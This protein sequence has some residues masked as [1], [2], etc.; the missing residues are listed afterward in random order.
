[1]IETMIEWAWLA[2]GVY[3][4]VGFALLVP[5][6]WQG[7]RAIDGNTAGAS[8][9]FRLIISPSL[10]ALWPV[11][12]KKWIAAR[13]SVSSAPSPDRPVS[14]SALRKTQKHLI[15]AVAVLT[16]VAVGIA[17]MGR[18]DFASVA[19][20]AVD[21]RLLLEI[22][23]DLELPTTVLYL[24]QAAGDTLSQSAI[25][26]GGIWGPASFSF[27]LPNGTEPVGMLKVYSLAN[28]VVVGASE[29][30]GRADGRS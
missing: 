7:L 28:G 23:A 29:I 3:A 26:L 16:P 1:M 30:A 25:A 10:V 11:V 19:P 20:P 12:L 4:L 5:I 18:A 2:A 17:L 15:G 8:I 24:D 13:S 27:V 14:A 9:G 6:H 22:E 21:G